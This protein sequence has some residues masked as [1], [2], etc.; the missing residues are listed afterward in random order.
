MNNRYNLRS[1]A[2]NAKGEKKVDEKKE[3]KEPIYFNLWEFCLMLFAKF[4]ENC[5]P[6]IYIK[7]LNKRFNCRQIEQDT[8]DKQDDDEEAE[9]EEEKEEEEA[10]KEEA[11]TLLDANLRQNKGNEKD[12]EEKKD[13]EKEEEEKEKKDE[14]E[15]K[16]NGNPLIRYAIFEILSKIINETGVKCAKAD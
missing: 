14:E 6:D 15:N 11:V 16:D 5:T 2:K 8:M 9:K 10:E 12:K 3:T 1:N 7:M 4:L 13:E